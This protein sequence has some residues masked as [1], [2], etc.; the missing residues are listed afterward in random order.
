MSGTWLSN[1][2]MTICDIF[3]KWDHNEIRCNFLR[4]QLK[5][6][7]TYIGRAGVSVSVRTSVGVVISLIGSGS[8]RGFRSVLCFLPCQ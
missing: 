4:V 2:I 8:G 7:C 1:P 5:L 3:I 6:I